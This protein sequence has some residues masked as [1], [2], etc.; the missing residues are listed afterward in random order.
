MRLDTPT[1]LSITARIFVLTVCSAAPS[2]PPTPTPALRGAL[3]LLANFPEVG[4]SELKDESRNAFALMNRVNLH[5]VQGNLDAARA[6]FDALLKL[7]QDLPSRWGSRG[8]LHTR[9]GQQKEA[10]A[11][12]DCELLLNPYPTAFYCNRGTSRKALR[13]KDTAIADLKRYVTSP[14][15]VFF[16]VASHVRRV[17]IAL[18]FCS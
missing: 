17:G 6:D 2:A 15:N 1:Q 13:N 8:S 3:T 18:A 4:E 14:G 11:D 16:E 7:Q 12:L 9:L 10:V 5:L